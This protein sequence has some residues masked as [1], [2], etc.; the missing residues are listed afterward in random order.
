MRL[1]TTA[2]IAALL[3]VAVVLQTTLFSQT[4][5]FVPDLV[6]LVVILLALT[7]LRP[8]GVLAIGFLAGLSV[9]LLGSAV[10][11]L[12][13]I[14][15]TIVAYL[16]LRTRERA[17]IGRIVTALWAGMLTFGGVVLLLL[18]GTLFGQRVLLGE[19]VVD[20]LILVPLA[21]LILSSIFAP[22]VV[23]LI[24]RDPTAFRYA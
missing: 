3:L 5:V 4:E 11:G 19:G 15:F 6:M 23:R 9:D 7:R 22:I 16:A 21:N 20:L 18:V 12:R 24:D 1:R 14:V 17:D 2:L 10:L 8:E 13:A